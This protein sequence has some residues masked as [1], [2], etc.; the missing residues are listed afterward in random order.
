MT[1]G[2][3]GEISQLLLGICIGALLAMAISK[4]RAARPGQLC[5]HQHRRYLFDRAV[6]RRSALDYRR[7]DRRRH[8]QTPEPAATVTYADLDPSTKGNDQTL[9]KR[10]DDAALGICGPAPVHSS[11][12]P[13]AKTLHQRCLKEAVNGAGRQGWRT[14]AQCPARA[15]SRTCR[16]HIRGAAIS[17]LTIGLSE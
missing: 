5:A 15:N 9:L 11:L 17:R 13:T 16:R 7:R 14:A 10:I 1:G 2:I 12:T 3:E 4:L 8:R 6:D